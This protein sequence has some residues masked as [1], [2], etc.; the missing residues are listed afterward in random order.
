LARAKGFIKTIEEFQ[1]SKNIP[2]QIFRKISIKNRW[3]ADTPLTNTHKTLG[4]KRKRI[5]KFL[6]LAAKAKSLALSKS[7]QEVSRM[8]I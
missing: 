2:N 7:L 1:Y 5:G 4:N 6:P 3:L 8:Q